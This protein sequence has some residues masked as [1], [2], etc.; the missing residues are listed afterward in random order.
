MKIKEKTIYRLIILGFLSFSLFLVDFFELLNLFSLKSIN[1][2]LTLATIGVSFYMIVVYFNDELEKERPLKVKDN[3][4]IYRIISVNV[5][6]L[7]L[8]TYIFINGLTGIAKNLN[9]WTLLIVLYLI[10]QVFILSVVHKKHSK[11]KEI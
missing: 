6:I 2:V 3:N 5:S 1:L 11:A 8:V 10:V 4:E 7:T 9:E